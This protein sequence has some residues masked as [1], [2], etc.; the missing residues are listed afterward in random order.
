M[1][2]YANVFIVR[3][4]NDRSSGAQFYCGHGWH[5]TSEHSSYMTK[6]NARYNGTI[7]EAQQCQE[8]IQF[9]WHKRA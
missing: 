8:F 2:P 9:S 1:L 5:G 4:V 7:Q 3:M 6:L